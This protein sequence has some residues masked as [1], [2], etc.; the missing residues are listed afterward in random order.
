MYC[1]DS[2]TACWALCVHMHTYMQ[3]NVLIQ[4]TTRV[5]VVRSVVGREGCHF[6]S[7]VVLAFLGPVC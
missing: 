5:C 4:V 7:V 3:F 6:V 1:A 2:G